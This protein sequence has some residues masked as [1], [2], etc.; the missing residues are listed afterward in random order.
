MRQKRIPKKLKH[1]A[2]VEALLEVRFQTTTIPEVLFGRLADY[3]PWK[4][5]TQ[6]RLPA[7]DLPALMR[8]ADPNLRFQPLFELR[9]EQN[10]QAVRLGGRVLSYHKLAPYS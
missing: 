7:Y 9:D 10:K 4:G 6:V 8:Q 3:A 2:I 5:F 1:D